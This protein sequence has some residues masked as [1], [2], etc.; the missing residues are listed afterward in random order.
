MNNDL[1]ASEERTRFEEEARAAAEYIANNVR[2]RT[3]PDT[4]SKPVVELYS[5]LKERAT[6]EDIPS[7]N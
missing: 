5:Y 1:P 7:A 2:G 3:V 4:T 6:N